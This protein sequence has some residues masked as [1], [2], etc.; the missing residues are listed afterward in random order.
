LDPLETAS[1]SKAAPQLIQ[2]ESSAHP[3]SFSMLEVLLT[4]GVC[5]A[6]AILFFPAVLESRDEARRTFCQNSFRQL[7]EA[8]TRYSIEHDTIPAIDPNSRLGFAGI[9]PVKLQEAG[10][11][12]DPT[13]L[14]CPG[15]EW[16][17][18]DTE[19]SVPS[20]ADLEAA[21][22]QASA[23]DL[24]ELKCRAAGSYGFN[25]GIYENGKYYAPVNERRWF[26]VWAADAPSF[27]L[28]HRIS[29]N[30][31][32]R[33]MNLLFEDGH[34]EFIHGYF[35]PRTQDDVLRSLY[36]LAEAGRDKDDSV[37]GSSIASPRTASLFWGE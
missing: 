28:P 14:I 15:S 36:G 2:P 1:G 23:H 12:P 10:L 29:A 16:A 7:G 25:L 32:G 26:F 24:W 35:V 6:M 9:I 18:Q 3:P 8:L 30:H 11:L 33:G 19:F 20:M 31:S 27:H 21:M 4:A 13:I 37:I 5:A 34:I 17:A 22:Q